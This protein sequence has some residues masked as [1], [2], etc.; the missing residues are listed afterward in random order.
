MVVAQC[1][2]LGV[3]VLRVCAEELDLLPL[4]IGLGGL[5][6]GLQEIEGPA[7]LFCSKKYNEK[8]R[9]G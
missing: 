8:E 6:A 5:G 1:L 9:K 7:L 2:E 4:F 3:F